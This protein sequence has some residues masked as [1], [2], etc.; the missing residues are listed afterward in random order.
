M[1]TRAKAEARKARAIEREQGFKMNPA[2]IPNM[3]DAL[4]GSGRDESVEMY[5]GPK[6]REI[7]QR[8]F[9]NL[10]IKWASHDWQGKWPAD[11]QAFEIHLPSAAEK[12]NPEPSFLDVI[13]GRQSVKDSTRDQ[14]CFLLALGVKRAGGRAAVLRQDGKCDIYVPQLG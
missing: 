1:T 6:G 13:P 8:L 11:W 9:P 14:I 12:T 2:E 10:V 5:A 3:A 7:I 4:F